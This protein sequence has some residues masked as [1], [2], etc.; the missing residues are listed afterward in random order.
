MHLIYSLVHLL[1]MDVS[2]S[3]LTTNK[4]V[5]SKS[6]ITRPRERRRCLQC[7]SRRIKCDLLRPCTECV[8][9]GV[10]CTPP[11]NSHLNSQRKPVVKPRLSEKATRQADRLEEII[12][13]LARDGSSSSYIPGGGFK[14]ASV[15]AHGGAGIDINSIDH[16][17]YSDYTTPSEPMARSSESDSLKQR[18]SSTIMHKPLQAP[19][20]KYSSY[21]SPTSWIALSGDVSRFVTS[22]SLWDN[23]ANYDKGFQLSRD[24]FEPR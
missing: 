6:R 13:Q 10:I 21:T 1:Q 22:H 17:S 18:T 11:D 15:S 7:E 24:E 16:H 8:R 19:I 3:G 5:K 12:E 20:N 14:E 2:R 23:L 9:S 4:V